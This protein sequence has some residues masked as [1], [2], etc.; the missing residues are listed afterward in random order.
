MDREDVEMIQA[1]NEEPKIEETKIEELE[2]DDH[3]LKYS[4][5]SLPSLLPKEPK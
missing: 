3:E 4:C 5:E 2:N 1:R